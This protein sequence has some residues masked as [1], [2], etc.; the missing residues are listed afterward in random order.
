MKI[1][2]DL[3]LR[4]IDIYSIPV[5]QSEFPDFLEHKKLFL[6]AIEEYKKEN[7]NEEKIN[8]NVHGYQSPP[9]LHSRTELNPLF[10]YIS[11]VA[12]KATQDLDFID[13]DVFV[14]S[15]WSNIND[16]RQCMNTQ[17]VHGDTLS[18][19]FYVKSPPGSG[20]LCITNCGINPMWAGFEMVR[21]TNINFDYVI[22]IRPDV[23]I[24]NKINMEWLNITFDIIVPNYE[25]NE[26]VND[27]FAIIPFDIAHHYANRIDELADFRKNHGRIVSEKYVQFI[28]IKYYKCVHLINFYMKIV[29]PDSLD[30]NNIV[31]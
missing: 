11:Q 8:S 17:H 3:E 28:I 31:V 1:V 29:R 6:E 30:T 25:F 26:G 10:E 14:S 13:C 22:F 12:I 18:G 19:V 7:S 15:S 5:W 24:S 4:C 21:K 9:G 20:Q 2:S 23:E 16:S 27:K